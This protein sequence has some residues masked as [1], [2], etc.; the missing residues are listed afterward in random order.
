M[1]L[2]SDIIFEHLAADFAIERFGS[3]PCEDFILK[4]VMFYQPDKPI[5][6]GQIYIIN[7]DGFP[8]VPPCNRQFLLVCLGGLPPKAWRNGSCNIFSVRGTVDLPYLFNAVQSI[9]SIYLD[10]DESLRDVLNDDADI[11]KMLLNSTSIF[12]NQIG[13]INENLEVIGAVGYA[14]ALEN[15][16]FLYDYHSVPPEPECVERM[17]TFYDQYANLKAPYLQDDSDH[18]R[19]Y[20][21]KIPINDKKWCCLSLSEVYRPLKNIDFALFRHFSQYIQKALY[22]RLN[23]RRS[24]ISSVRS[25]LRKLLNGEHVEESQLIGSVSKVISAKDSRKYPWVCLVLHPHDETSFAVPE[26]IISALAN[27][28]PDGI[29]LPYNE[30]III[31]MQTLEDRPRK[32]VLER[33][34]PLLKSAGYYIGISDCFSEIGSL[35]TAYKK[36]CLAIETGVVPG[37]DNH[38][39]TFSDYA[40]RYMLR[41]ITGEFQIH[42]LLPSGLASL[43]RHDENSVVSYVKTL[44]CFMSNH[45]NAA[46]TA[47][48]LYLHRSSLIQRLERI[49]EILGTRM[50]SRDEQLF[51]SIL[52]HLLK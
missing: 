39:Y 46:K 43:I 44:H 5:E 26:Y 8:D 3:N 9:F 4:S 17:R 41:H 47:R 28:M 30:N 1:K 42:D 23:A 6:D 16:W 29:A 15:P 21:I 51:Y 50:E 12:E 18:N 13:V 10:W 45:M 20:S 40:F 49:F 19:V 7:H 14:E 35:S 22:Y 25:H 24:N 32:I 31:L 33:I 38:V 34:M 27:Y 37:E 52:L 11:G 36:A 48:E 2:S